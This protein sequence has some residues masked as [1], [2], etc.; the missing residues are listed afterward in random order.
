MT[1][2]KALPFAEAPDSRIFSAGVESSLSFR[3]E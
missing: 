2:I 3:D 1:F